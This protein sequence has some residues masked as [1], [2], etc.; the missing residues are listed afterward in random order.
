MNTHENLMDSLLLWLCLLLLLIWFHWCYWKSMTAGIQKIWSNHVICQIFIVSFVMICVSLSVSVSVSLSPSLL[1]PPSL[2]LS[3]LIMLIEILFLE[4][5]YLLN[6]TQLLGVSTH[7][8]MLISSHT[9]R[10]GNCRNVLSI[11]VFDLVS[12][13]TLSWNPSHLRLCYVHAE[14]GMV[15]DEFFLSTA[16]RYFFWFFSLYVGIWI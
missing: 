8:W 13:Y 2:S 10:F 12:T 5:H 14:H 9:I 1:C 3:Y 7:V 16:G 4:W 6:G 15:L 11:S